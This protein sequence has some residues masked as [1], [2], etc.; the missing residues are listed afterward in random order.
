MIQRRR[1]KRQT[2]AWWRRGWFPRLSAT[3]SFA[4]GPGWSSESL[5]SSVTRLSSVS[6]EARRSGSTCIADDSYYPIETSWAGWSGVTNRSDG[7]NGANITRVS[8]HSLHTVKTNRQSVEING[9]YSSLKTLFSNASLFQNNVKSGE[10]LNRGIKSP[11]NINVE[12][13]GSR[14]LQYPTGIAM[15]LS[16]TIHRSFSLP[17]QAQNLLSW[18]TNPSRV[19]PG[20]CSDTC[21]AYNRRSCTGWPKKCH[22]FFW[23]ALTSSNINRFSKLL[24]CQNQEKTCNNTST[25]DPYTPQMCRYNTLFSIFA[26]QTLDIS[27]G[28][29]ATHLRRGGIFSD[30]I[31]EWAIGLTV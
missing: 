24:H 25:K 19:L 7:S 28:S 1:W 20:A 6:S 29:V 9:N 14:S 30:S 8:C 27:H 16:F 21:I 11:G 18:S 22:S 17:L 23:Y 13:W 26:F 3:S 10:Q 15:L 2:S 4:S 31:V 12:T 5:L